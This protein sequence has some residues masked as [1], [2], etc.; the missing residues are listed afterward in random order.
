MNVKFLKKIET[1]TETAKTF[2]VTEILKVNKYAYNIHFSYGMYKCYT[3]IISHF[4]AH[5]NTFFGETT[6]KEILISQL[7]TGGSD[8][9]YQT[10]GKISLSEE[11]CK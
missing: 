9:Y 2:D 5:E 3:K 4:Q 11:T 6:L 10:T 7:H 8:S 1:D